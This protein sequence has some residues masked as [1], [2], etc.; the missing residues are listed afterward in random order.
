LLVP[1][2]EECTLL[3]HFTWSDPGGF[4]GMI[5]GLVLGRALRGSIEGM[6]RLA[7]ERYRALP[8]GPPFVRPD[9]TPLRQASFVSESVP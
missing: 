5:Q 7:D 2:A 4:V 1:L 8:D 6:V 3:E 9:G